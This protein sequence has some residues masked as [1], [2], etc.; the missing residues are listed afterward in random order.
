MNKESEASKIAKASAAGATDTTQDMPKMMRPIAIFLGPLL[1]SITEING[2]VI[3]QSISSRSAVTL[4]RRPGVTYPY[5]IF[6][7]G[8]IQNKSTVKSCATNSDQS[9]AEQPKPNQPLKFSQRRPFLSSLGALVSAAALPFQSPNHAL[10]RGLVQFPCN[11]VKL[12][13][14]YHLMRSGQSLLEERDILS[15]NPLFLTNRENSLSDLG[16]QQ[17]EEACRYIVAQEG[18][19]PTIVGYSLAANCVDSAAIVGKELR[20]GQNRLVPEFTFLDPRAVGK[21][22]ILPL[23]T[24]Q[25]AIWAMDD[26]EAGEYGS[27]GRPPPND[28]GTPNETL[29]DQVIRLRQYFSGEPVLG[30]RFVKI[31]HSDRSHQ[32]LYLVLYLPFNEVL[33]SFYSGDTVLIIFPDGTGPALLTCLIGGKLTHVFLAARHIEQEM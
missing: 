20:L 32:L 27:N 21:W 18:A 28:D 25:E 14:T 7:D 1:V 16:M 30:S 22:D 33:E 23:Q 24:T 5:S 10:A 3:K 4:Y 11:K 31:L 9:Q 12:Q 6:H 13:N 8:S 17:V 19:T 29:A 2:I 26:A 15:T